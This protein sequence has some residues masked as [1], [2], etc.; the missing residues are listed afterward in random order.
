MRILGFVTISA[1]FA[2]GC[3]DSESPSDPSGGLSER[4]QADLLFTREEEKL[5][6]DV[7]DALDGYG[8][9][10]VNIQSSEQRHFDAVGTLLVTYGLPDP[11]AGQPIGSFV[12]PRL[13]ELYDELVA[14]GAPSRL[15][16]LGVGCTIEELDLRD[17]VVA[18][19]QTTRADIRT[20]Y[21]N[22]LLGSRN[23]LRAFY[24]QLVAAGGAYTPIY[25]DQPA[26]DAIVSSPREQGG[27]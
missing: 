16:A 4:E 9:A 1:A 22:L 10:F 24:G 27:M 23:H 6:R 13:Q 14:R 19:A 12:D 21:D 7:Y 25:L 20:V 5:A 26:F 11:A 8:Q 15:A 18:Q 17:L 2:L 3:T